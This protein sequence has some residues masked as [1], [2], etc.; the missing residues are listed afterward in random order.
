MTLRLDVNAN[1]LAN[2]ITII[3]LKFV[4]ENCNIM[5]AIRDICNLNKVVRQI[6]IRKILNC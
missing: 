3:E 5:I 6:N 4:F 1:G 2:T